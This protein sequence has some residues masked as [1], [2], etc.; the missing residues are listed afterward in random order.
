MSQPKKYLKFSDQY[1]YAYITGK[2]TAELEE[3]IPYKT[4]RNWIND[5]LDHIIG[6]SPDINELIDRE[7]EV[8]RIIAQRKRLYAMFK[9]MI[10]L[11][12]VSEK[13]IRSLPKKKTL[14]KPFRFELLEAFENASSFIPIRKNMKRFG[15]T[16]HQIKYWRKKRNEC[17]NSLLKICLKKHPFQISLP[18]IERISRIIS[19]PKYRFYS[20]TEI[21]EAAKRKL[22]IGYALPTFKKLF[23]ILKDDSQIKEFFRF[24]HKP[25]PKADYPLERIHL[26]ITEFYTLNGTKTYISILMDNHSRFPIAWYANLNKTPM[27]TIKCLDKLRELNLPESVELIVDG[28]SENKNK[29]VDNYIAEH[30]PQVKLLEARKDVDYSNSMIEAFNKHIKYSYLF[31]EPIYMFEGLRTFLDK[32]MNDY[33]LKPRPVLKGRTPLEAFEQTPYPLSKEKWKDHCRKAKEERIKFNK[34]NFCSNS[35]CSI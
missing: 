21:Y 19:N 5:G 8:A 3:L 10:P 13:I 18:E 27:G 28:G 24:K 12:Q 29:W 33:I 11:I 2:L 23:K 30:L 4:R 20:P 15:I 32:A 25:T 1:K 7:I 22:L 17:R 16:E 31:R 9:S 26:D 14:L 6:F 35:K 34:T